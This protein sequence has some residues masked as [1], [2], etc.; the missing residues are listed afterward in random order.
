MNAVALKAPRPLNPKSADTKYTGGEPEWR[1]QPESESRASALIAAFTWYNY[2]YDKKTVKE[3]VIDW[4]IRNDRS[5]DA[6]DFVR[7]PESTIRNQT[8]WLCRMNIMGLDLNE[9][10]L[11]AVDTAITEHLRTVRAIREVVKAA[12]PDAVAR[13]NIQD[14]LRDKMVEAAGE[15]E[16]MYDDMIVAGAKMSAD[17]K[18]LLVLRGMNVAPQMVGEIAQHWKSRLEELEEV[19]RGK[20]AQLVEGYGQFGK[21]QVKN[22]VK[23][24]EQ[25][26]A[27][28]GS[29]VQIKKVE[30]KPRK[31]KPVSTEKLTARF[32]Y[33]RE[34]A[35]LKLQSE[36]VTRLVNAQEAW[37]YE[38]KKRKLIYVVADTHAGSFTV[39]GSSLIGFDPTNSVQKTLRKPAEQIK[40]LLQGGVAQ[41]RKYFKDIRATEIKFNGRGSENLILL[42]IR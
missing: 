41:H 14:R 36:P 32:K 12:E 33:L 38:T 2:H 27:D 15:I 35:E 28:C 8:G 21:L 3:L 30:R 40:A 1:L 19:I 42:K 34:F 11:L 10:E 5:R 20:D 37:L 24:A 7:V 31:K 39:K 25:V 18:P 6:K 17:F 13:P 22:L 23:F 26:I 16:G 29:Y 9:H 4:L